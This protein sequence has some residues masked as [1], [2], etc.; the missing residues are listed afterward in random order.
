MMFALLGLHPSEMCTQTQKN[1]SKNIQSS[2]IHSRA[3][4]ETA[5]M[6]IYDK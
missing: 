6:L 2:F 4:P 3:Q 1:M 5:Q